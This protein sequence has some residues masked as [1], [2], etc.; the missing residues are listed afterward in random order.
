MKE[1]VGMKG[2]QRGKLTE[3]VAAVSIW[4]LLHLLWIEEVIFFLLRMRLG[5]LVKKKKLRRGE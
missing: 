2:Q 3:Q 1:L 4:S 5:F